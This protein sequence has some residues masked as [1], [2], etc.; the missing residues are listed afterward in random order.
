ML[1]K[2]AGRA[3]LAGLAGW[4][5]RNM[6][7]HQ[8]ALMLRLKILNKHVGHTLGPDRAKIRRTGPRWAEQ[9]CGLHVRPGGPHKDVGTGPGPGG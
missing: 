2:L 4:R 5:L 3:G 7:F 8:V 1:A 9:A 6:D